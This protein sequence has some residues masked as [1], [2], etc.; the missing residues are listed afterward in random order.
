MVGCTLPGTRSRTVVAINEPYRAT[1]KKRAADRRLFGAGVVGHVAISIR[2]QPPPCPFHWPTVAS[3]FHATLLTLMAGTRVF[4]CL[5]GSG[6]FLCVRAGPRELYVRPL[7][8]VTSQ[9]GPTPTCSGTRLARLTLQFIELTR[10][11][12]PFDPFFAGSPTRAS[13]VR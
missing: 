8:R 4:S 5:I 11:Q 1:T 13:F 12:Q 3:R 9:G 7:T 6:W 2:T 10:T